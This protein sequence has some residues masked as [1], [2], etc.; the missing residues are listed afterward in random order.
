[1]T[2]PIISIIGGTGNEGKGLAYRWARGGYSVLI[3][4]RQQEKAE[5]AV[6]EIKQLANIPLDISGKT[7]EEASKQGD[8]IVLTVPFSAHRVTLESIKENL[9]G[10]IFIDV[11]VPLVPPKVTKVQMPESGSALMQA[12][13]ILGKEVLVASA[14][15]NV[16]HELLLKDQEIDCDVLVCG[17]NREVRVAVLQLVADAGLTGRDAGP[18][19]NSVV[20]EGLTSILIGLNIKHKVHSAGIKITGLPRD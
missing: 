1:M 18:I 9:I 5:N 13:E 14:F 2:K 8:V 11:S 20:V 7:N 19:E 6:N 4:S 17:E 15:Q 16:S 3:G 12:K 10:K